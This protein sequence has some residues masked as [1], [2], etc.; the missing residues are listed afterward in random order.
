MADLTV[1]AYVS[2]GNPKNSR[3][4]KNQL[5]KSLAFIV[6]NR[7]R[8]HEK[9]FS[10]VQHSSSKYHRI[11]ALGCQYGARKRHQASPETE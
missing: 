10:L 3:N 7:R 8:S 4:P 5:L 11:I 1:F 2:V 6:G 9:A